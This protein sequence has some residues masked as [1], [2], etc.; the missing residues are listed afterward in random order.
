[1]TKRNPQSAV[2]TPQLSPLFTE[3][4]AVR[5]LRVKSKASLTTLRRTRRLGY[6][7]IGRHIRFTREDLERCIE[8]GRF[9]AKTQRAR[10]TTDHEGSNGNG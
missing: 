9:T 8:E 2:R 6:V 4:E 10:R 7:K 5:I 1:M 3:E